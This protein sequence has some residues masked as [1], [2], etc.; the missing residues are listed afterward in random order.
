MPVMISV[1]SILFVHAGISPEMVQRNLTI[2]QINSKFSEN[3]IAETDEDVKYNEELDFLDSG[4][5]PVWYR[6][7]F[8]DTSF[9][10]SKIDSILDFYGKDHI[11]IGHTPNKGIKSLFNN[12]V[13]DTDTGIMYSQPEEMLLYKNGFFY[14]VFLNGTRI[15]VK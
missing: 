13:F 2:E 10:E 6:G 8:T 5:G 14:R 9:C 1:D 15:K 3:F 7:Y 11:V 12:K 4:M